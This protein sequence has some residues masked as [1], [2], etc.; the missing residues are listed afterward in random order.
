MAVLQHDQERLL[1]GDRAQEAHKKGVKEVLA[2]HR[3]DRRCVLVVSQAEPEQGLEK[4]NL[5]LEARIQS[6]DC[7]PQGCL[8]ARC[9]V[10]IGEVE[11]VPPDR[12]PYGVRTVAFEACRLSSDGTQVGRSSQ[13]AGFGDEARLRP[14]PRLPSGSSRSHGR[15]A[16]LRGASKASRTRP[17]GRRAPQGREAR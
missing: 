17:G 16:R 2:N 11:Q 4:G 14:L 12:A 3:W 6:G 1:S 7:R 10:V 9:G 13:A 5:P 8:D 15:P